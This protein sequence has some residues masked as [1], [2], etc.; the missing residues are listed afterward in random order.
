MSFPIIFYTTDCPPNQVTKTFVK[1][2]S[3]DDGAIIATGT[4]RDGAS[5][6][7]PVVIIQ[8]DPTLN[9]NFI[10]EKNYMWI[11]AFGRYYYIT[12]ISTPYNGLWEVHGHVDVLMSFADRIR[13]QTAIVAKQEKKYN[14]LLDDGSFMTYQNPKFQTKLFSVSDPFE[15]QEFV[16]V[17]AGS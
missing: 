3:G 1:A 10:K 8:P 4:L 14:L 15:V 2:E 9:P 5:L 11:E 16:L 6:L 13:Q 7:D 17:V 12:N